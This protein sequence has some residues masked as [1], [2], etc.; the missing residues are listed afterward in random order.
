MTLLKAFLGAL[1]VL[2]LSIAAPAPEIAL[3]ARA[4]SLPLPQRVLTQFA[5]GTWIESV[6]VRANGD[7]LVTILLPTAAVYSVSDP[8]SANPVVSL[9]HAFP[10][11]TGVVGITKTRADV[12][13]VNAGNFTG[14]ANTVNGTSLVYEMNMCG[15]GPGSKKTPKVRVAARLPTAQVLNGLVALPGKPTTVLA[16]DSALGLVW[17]IDTVTGAYDVAMQVPEMAAVPTAAVKFGVNGVK[18]RGGYLYFSNS[19]TATIFRIAITKTGSMAA[20]AVVEKV[21]TFASPWVD[22]FT[23]G[24]ETDG[25]IWAS[26][27]IGNTIVAVYPNGTTV[28]VEGAFTQLTV[29]GATAVEFGRTKKDAHVLY[30]STTG[31]LARPVN[32]TVMEGGKVVAIDTAG[33]A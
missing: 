33:F 31:G 16:A 23:F 12:F 2:P 32:G 29:A 1:L 19:N 9:V 13:A 28:T 6:T 7:L 24:P 17:R 3:S 8:S 18:I 5:R 22:D 20:G 14:I 26:T 30:V 11:S 21:V 10:D 15:V 27:N 4:V 25:L